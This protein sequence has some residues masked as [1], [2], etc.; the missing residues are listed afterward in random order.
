MGGGTDL[1][2]GLLEE[3]GFDGG[4]KLLQ[5]ILQQHRCPEPAA[6]RVEPHSMQWLQAS[7]H[8]MAP[9]NRQVG[10]TNAAVVIWHIQ[11]SQGYTLPLPFQ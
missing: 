3:E 7:L 5:H 9:S 4:V 10:R 2:E 8:A 1:L 6:F 11:D